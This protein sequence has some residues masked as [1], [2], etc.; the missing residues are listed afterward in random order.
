MSTVSAAQL[1]IDEVTFDSR[2]WWNVDSLWSSTE[3]S[4][5]VLNK[6]ATWP[7]QYEVPG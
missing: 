1:V 3:K 2:D 7:D 4:S 6:S 5:C